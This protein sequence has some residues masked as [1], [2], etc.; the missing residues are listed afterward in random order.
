MSAQSFLERAA[1][2]DL[3]IR[4]VDQRLLLAYAK[5]DVHPKLLNRLLAVR[6][7]LTRQWGAAWN[8]RPVERRQVPR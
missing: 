3:A 4:H 5:P 6:N 2:L 1:E 7:E 8:T